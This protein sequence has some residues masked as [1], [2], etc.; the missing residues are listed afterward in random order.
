[1]NASEPT[2]F[3]AVRLSHVLKFFSVSAFFF[4]IVVSSIILIIYFV[5]KM[6]AT[7]GQT[8][9]AVVWG[10]YG[11]ETQYVYNTALLEIH[12]CR[13]PIRLHVVTTR[14]RGLARNRI[15]AVRL[16]PDAHCEHACV[17]CLLCR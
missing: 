3:V 4:L 15:R 11:R 7:I 14:S 5:N 8:R 17:L 12:T 13:I 2:R 6:I 1:M 10:G 16:F 9:D